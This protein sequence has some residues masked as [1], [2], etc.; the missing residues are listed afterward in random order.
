MVT[1]NSVQ[2]NVPLNPF[3]GAV[4]AAG[5]SEQNDNTGFS[6]N[7]QYHQRQFTPRIDGLHMFPK[8]SQLGQVPNPTGKGVSQ[9]T[10]IIDNF[11]ASCG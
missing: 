7:Q 3:A 6:R 9:R 11:N 8:R 5:P 1:A 2:Q 4:G 10:I